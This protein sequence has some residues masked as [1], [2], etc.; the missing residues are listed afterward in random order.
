MANP[1]RGEAELIVNGKPYTL[2]LSMNA[3]AQLQDRHKKTV[4]VVVQEAMS[5]DFKAIRALVWVF[6]QKC[7][8][9]EFKREE[10]AGDFIDEAG[11][12]NVLETLQALGALNSDPDPNAAARANGTGANSTSVLDASA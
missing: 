10:Q 8:A 4:G 12:N 3:A 9:D 7:H 11:L 6:L 5:L 2:K 1:E